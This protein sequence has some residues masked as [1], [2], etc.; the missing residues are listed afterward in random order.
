ML[1]KQLSYD[2]EYQQYA[3]QLATY[4]LEQLTKEPQR[5]KEERE[6]IENESKS[7]AFKNYK[8]FIQSGHCVQHVRTGV[9]RK[10]VSTSI[11]K[12]GRNR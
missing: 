9:S 10:N 12:K 8:A 4:S 6:K 1:P 7:V 11:N 3:I 2:A 5:I